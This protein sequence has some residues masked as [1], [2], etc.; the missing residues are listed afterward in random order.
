MMKSAYFMGSSR[1]L[2]KRLYGSYSALG[3]E[4]DLIAN[5]VKQ[6]LLWPISELHVHPRL[7]LRKI[8]MTLL[9]LISAS[10]GYM[11]YNAKSIPVISSGN[12]TNREV[13][14]VV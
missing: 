1:R 5:M 11:M 14:E 8:L 6:G 12:V 4:F 7:A 13:H 10:F 2:Q 9:I 3:I